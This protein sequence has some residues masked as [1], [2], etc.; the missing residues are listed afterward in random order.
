MSQRAVRKEE[1][2][3]LAKRLYQ[4]Q[5]SNSF[6]QM[7]LLRPALPET[8]VDA[9]ILTTS[10]FGKE[11]AA[12]FFINAMTGGSPQSLRINQQLGQVAAK[13]HLALALGSASILVKD[14]GQLDSFIVAR[15]ENPDGI[16]IANLNP[17]TPA[18]AAAEIVTELKADALQLHLNTVQ[19]AV[20][21]EGDRDFRFLANLCKIRQEVDVPIIIKEVGFGLDFAS[22]QRLKQEGFTLFDVAGAGGTNFA[23][24]ENQRNPQDYSYFEQIGLS[25]VL[26]ALMAKKAQVDFIVSGGV[27]NPLDVLKGLALGGRYVGVANTFL[28]VL[29]NQDAEALLRQI[30]HW[31]QQLAILLAV[32]GVKN[33]AACSNLGKSY[34]CELKNQIDQLIK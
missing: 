17:Q 5:K 23:Q 13:S 28:N 32:Y 19:E 1:H 4:K 15:Q 31:Q 12:P 18:K 34:S 21:P 8:K 25:T 16:V 20:M 24:I 7:F 30:Q 22:I 33:L 9:K 14:K 2:L 11:I 26:A 10:M 29:Q 6:D 27:R 3:R